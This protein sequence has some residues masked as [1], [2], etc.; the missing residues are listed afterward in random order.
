MGIFISGDTIQSPELAQHYHCTHDDEVDPIKAAE[1]MIA[2]EQPCEC[3][4]CK[5]LV[6][7]ARAEWLARVTA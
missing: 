7:E 1:R 4:D 6:A 2:G 5:L 3:F